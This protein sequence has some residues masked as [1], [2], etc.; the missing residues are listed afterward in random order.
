MRQQG[1]KAIIGQSN[2]A[3]RG[4]DNERTRIAS[5]PYSPVTLLPYRLIALFLLL[6]AGFALRLYRIDVQNIWWDEARNIDVASRPLLAI[7]G[8]P[9]LDIHPPLY[10]YLLHFWMRLLGHS[11]FAVRL[12]SAFFGLLSAPLLYALGRRVGGRQAGV[13]ALGIGA[14]APF[15]LAEAQETRM[16]TVTFVWLLGAAYCL[17]RAMEGE[18]KNEGRIAKGRWWTGYTLLA[19]ASVLTHYS[20][21]FVLAPWQVWIALRAVASALS[22][23]HLPTGE[24]R[25]MVGEGD[26]AR[27]I[28]ILT[29]AFLAGLGMIILFLPQAPIALRQIPTYRNPNLTVPSLGAY[30]L[31]CAREYVLGPALSL[32]TG[33]PWLWGLAVGG[34]L[35]LAL[36]LWHPRP[37]EIR[38]PQSAIQGAWGLLFLFTWLA[39]GLAFYYVILVDRAT[40]H[41]R[42]ISFVTPALYAL[43]GLALTGWWRT[44]RPL[45]LVIALALAILVIPAVRADQFDERF[46]SEDTAGL[47]AWLM[48]TATAND[49]ILIDVP[50]PLGIY[51]PRYARLGEPPPEPAELAP[52]RYLFVDI[53]TIAQ[54]LTEL[55]AGRERLFWIRWFKSDTDPRGVVSFLL[56]KFAAR[57]GEQAFRGYQVDVYRLPQPALFELA[58]ALEPISV[59]FGPVELT[60]MAFG[61]R[62]GEPTSSLEE[63]RR[64]VAPAD[65]IVWAV[66]SW[67]RL[68]SVDR[69]YKA[70]LYLEDRFGQRVGQDDRPLLNDRHLT[71]PH[72]GDGE[73]AL[74]VYA[75]PLAVGSPP[76]TY[77]LKV[78][79]YDPDTGERLSRLDAAGAAQGTDAPLGTIEVI[80]PLVPP[81]LERMGNTAVGP[82]RWGDVT[83][84][85]ADLPGGEIA[86]GAIVSLPLYWR[87][88]VDAPNAA[89]VRLAL[90][91]GDREWSIRRAAP[92]DG[93]YPFTRWAAGEVVRDTHPWRLDPQMPT[94]EYAVH[95]LLEATDGRVLGETTLGTLH[96]AGRPR[97]FD[98]PP[99]QYSVGARLGDVAELLGYDVIEP[100]TPGGILELTLYWRAIA[101]S[102]WPLT[103]FVHLLDHESRVRGQVDRIPGD[104]AYPTTGWLPGE[105]L[106]DVYRVPVAADLP[107]GRYLV[108]VG[109]YDPATGARLPITDM[110]GNPLGDRVLLGP[111][112]VGP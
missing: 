9:E 80:R 42:Y 51:Y 15:L 28:R 50:Y 87:A 25:G 108:E 74:N 3:M 4:R 65:K 90:R 112:V 98:V 10:F 99:I 84:L 23:P 71:L 54:R 5:S 36:F 68:S 66:L 88:E 67:R 47:A 61:G 104:G 7:A 18:A 13:L 20:A 33:A 92:V 45:G 35:G 38:N 62:G 75:V 105:V 12:L 26:W 70:T 85:G 44:W 56:D 17:L 2:K 8:S 24:S 103:V 97:R 60:A 21:V 48:K 102:T 93:S 19:A 77:M 37:S 57:E 78:A 95:L 31:D 53:H 72:W 83:L 11:E 34:A 73:E 46:F 55:S 79:V 32:T 82:L 89:T 91:D 39:G 109:L 14:L 69:P 43:I 94:G 41:P 64:R 106:T 40:F 101:P 29:R 59:R 110:A 76:G 1:N 86:P 30:L 6:W 100:T 52:A 96:V 107:P 81:A 49:L 58:S 63:T 16:Y 111:V 27:G 22:F